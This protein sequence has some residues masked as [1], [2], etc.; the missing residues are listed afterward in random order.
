MDV[1]LFETT[2]INRAR[3]LMEQN[4]RDMENAFQAVV[5]MHKEADEGGY[6]CFQGNL[7]PINRKGTDLVLSS[8]TLSQ[9]IIGY[10]Q[11]VMKLFLDI[12]GREKTRHYFLSGCRQSEPGLPEADKIDQLQRSTL[13]LVRSAARAHIRELCRIV[14]DDGLVFVSDHALHGQGMFVSE[15]EVEVDVQRLVPYSKNREEEKYLSRRQ[16]AERQ[17]PGTVRAA[18]H[19]PD[20]TF[21]VGGADALKTLLTCY[22]GI[23]ILSEYRWWWVTERVN[24][25]DRESPDWHISYVET[26]A[27]RPKRSGL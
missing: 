25:L 2:L 22:N 26:Y 12:F 19:H 5:A 18:I 24:R 16:G 27:F 11:I 8:M 6:G 21:A 13:P 3:N 7:L 15:D 20:E 14:K 1:S 10:I 9:L 4:S 23:E 17:L